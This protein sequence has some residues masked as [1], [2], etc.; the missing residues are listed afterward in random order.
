MSFTHSANCSRVTV[1]FSRRSAQLPVKADGQR[2]GG[3]G[4]EAPT[5][6]LVAALPQSVFD[7]PDSWKMGYP[8]KRWRLL[9]ETNSCAKVSI[10]FFLH[11]APGLSALPLHRRLN[12]LPCVM[13]R[14]PTNCSIWK[15]TRVKV[16]KS[17]VSFASAVLP[18][19][20]QL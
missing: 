16:S 5:P 17:V 1:A 12:K 8:G 2:E 18:T 15:K 6:V 14:A 20:N 19:P 3:S 7:E 13:G 10:S 9:E 11:T 4:L